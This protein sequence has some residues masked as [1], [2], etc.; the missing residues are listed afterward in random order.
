MRMTFDIKGELP[1][2]RVFE[3]IFFEPRPLLEGWGDPN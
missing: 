1:V 2:Q 3:G